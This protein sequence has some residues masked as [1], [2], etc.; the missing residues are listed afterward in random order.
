MGLY[1]MVTVVARNVFE[2]VRSEISIPDV[3]ARFD[4][5][6]P[7]EKKQPVLRG[8]RRQRKAQWALLPGRGQGLLLFLLVLG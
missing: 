4:R 5:H 3:L 2:A 1:N 7:D 6:T 8:P